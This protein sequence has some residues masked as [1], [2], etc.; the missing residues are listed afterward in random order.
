MPS[1]I[2]FSDTQPTTC[3]DDAVTFQ[4]DNLVCEI[5][6]NKVT[7]K[8]IHKN[9]VVVN[10]TN[11][12]RLYHI[13]FPET[14]IHQNFNFQI[15]YKDSSDNDMSEIATF[16]LKIDFVTNCNIYFTT[17]I[18][19]CK[20]CSKNYNLNSSDG[21]CYL[22]QDACNTINPN[23][24]S[25]DG[26]GVCIECSSTFKLNDT[27]KKCENTIVSECT[28]ENCS[29]CNLNEN[30]KCQTC[31]NGYILN[32]D[33]TICEIS[34]SVDNCKI[35]EKNSYNVCELC[36]PFYMLNSSKKCQLKSVSSS[37]KFFLILQINF[38]DKF[39][40]IGFVISMVLFVTIAATNLFSRSLPKPSN[41]KKDTENSRN[42][43]KLATQAKKE[44]V[45]WDVR[46]Y[47]TYAYSI[48][49]FVDIILNILYII[50]EEKQDNIDIS[51]QVKVHYV[52]AV[53]F[54]FKLIDETQWIIFL[55]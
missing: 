41:T 28:I 4:N 55:V 24:G 15:L 49:Y 19:N 7:T 13:K 42:V 52:N 6:E 26:Q 43:I 2:S 20:E 1:T 25:C 10:T 38:K 31:K 34:C 53:S 11:N 35:C 5:S 8:N 3:A 27:T 22:N 30:Q 48:I 33:S 12:L 21:L 9:D 45:V 40:S 29:A 17:N 37:L 39:I 47:L 46:C 14:I 50:W 51:D 23:C 54:N 18:K 44:Q 36:N 16:D 32:S